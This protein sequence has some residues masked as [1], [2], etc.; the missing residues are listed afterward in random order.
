MRISSY[1]A[2]QLAGP[3]L[4]FL[5]LAT[6]TAQNSQRTAVTLTV[7]SFAEP[8]AAQDFRRERDGDG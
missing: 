3:P 5:L 2:L 7:L 8:S 1:D 4:P 6:K